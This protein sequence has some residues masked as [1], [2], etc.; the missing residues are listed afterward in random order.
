MPR[1]AGFG[2]AREREV[3]VGS[4]VVVETAVF[5]TRYADGDG[6]SVPA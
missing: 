6:R 1:D 2:T 3:V 4:A 5:A